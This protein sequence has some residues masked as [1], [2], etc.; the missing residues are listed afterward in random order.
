MKKA[1][2]RKRFQAFDKFFITA[3][4]IILF[5]S[6]RDKNHI[7]S[8]SF[9]DFDHSGLKQN[10][11]YLFIP[12]K[13]IGNN[14]SFHKNCSLW[15]AVRYSDKCKIKSIPLNIEISS[16]ELDTILNLEKDVDLFSTDDHPLGKG[17]YGIY[18]TEFNLLED[19]QVDPEMKVSVSTTE[20][21]TK[22]IMSM[23]IICKNLF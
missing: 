6:C 1:M 21:D 14:D 4:F 3:F 5:T 11:E 20:P 10:Q 8:S 7:F 15:I 17:H 19:L 22:G 2:N 12:C 13:E 23:G 9:I 16:P 18:E